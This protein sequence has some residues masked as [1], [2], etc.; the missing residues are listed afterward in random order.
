VA[1]VDGSNKVLPRQ[2]ENPVGAQRA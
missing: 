2:L 1:L